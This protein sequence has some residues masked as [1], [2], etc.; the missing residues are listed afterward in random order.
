[1][2]YLLDTNAVIAL[3]GQK[4]PS[5]TQRVLSCVEGDIGLPTVVAY[6][7]YYGAYK[8]QKTAYNL[9]TL[10]LVFRDMP[11][12]EFSQ[13]DARVAGEVRSILAAQGSP[14]G[15][16]DVLIAGQAKSRG[17]TLITH[18]M[19][20]FSHVDGLFLEDWM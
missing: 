15:P 1:M 16:Y 14:I 3:V 8:S 5:L 7:L 10:R 19:G 4:S 2:K 13:E 11:V 6:E 18:N 12:L 9:E 17:Q 20:E